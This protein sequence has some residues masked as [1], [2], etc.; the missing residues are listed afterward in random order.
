MHKQK[1]ANAERELIALFWKSGWAA[2][3]IAGSGSSRF[4]SPDIIAGNFS[5]KLAIECK[6]TKAKAQYITKE[7]AEG[8]KK[9]SEIF[10]AEPWVGVRF[11][12]KEWYFMPL[13]DIKQTENQN[14]VIKLED[15]KLMGLKFNELLGEFP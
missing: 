4:P 8:L 14:L 11:S 9:F 7:Q 2:H 10:G 1:G 3:R 13:K 6:S 15:A 5:K 12:K